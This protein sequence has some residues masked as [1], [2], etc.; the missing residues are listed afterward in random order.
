MENTVQEIVIG[1]IESYI[2]LCMKLRSKQFWSFR[3]Q[4]D[5][6]WDLGPH[7]FDDSDGDLSLLNQEDIHVKYRSKVKRSVNMFKR[8]FSESFEFQTLQNKSDEWMWQFYAQHYGL[9]TMLLDWTSNP[10]VALYFAVENV[11][12]SSNNQ[13]KIGAVWALNA[14]DSR[15]FTPNGNINPMDI[16]IWK[17]VHPPPFAQ[18]V[19]RMIRQ[20]GKFTI[21]PDCEPIEGKLR[22]ND[23]LLKIIINDE[24]SKDNTNPAERIRWQLGIMNIHH[25][26]MFPESENITKYLNKQW[27]LISTKEHLKTIEGIYY[28]PNQEYMNRTDS[29]EI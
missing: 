8:Y 13:D 24:L 7:I 4:R 9:K 15:V 6:Q 1:D 25:A 3:G 10:L 20:S 27:S 23:K 11:L 12:S 26:S 2:N 29:L 14:G 22:S 18:I 16:D 28:K 21:H 19:P 17:I 5:Y